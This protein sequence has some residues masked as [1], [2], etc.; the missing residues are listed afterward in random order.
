MKFYKTQETIMI[1]HRLS[2]VRNT[3][4]IVLV[5]NGT[6]QEYG[7]H[8]ELIELK[9]RYYEMFTKQAENYLE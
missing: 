4:K 9:G 2:T 5:E 8:D 7:T 6:I 3:D 1:A